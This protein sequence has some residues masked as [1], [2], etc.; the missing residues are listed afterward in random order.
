MIILDDLAKVSVNTVI[1]DG[2]AVS[3]EGKLVTKIDLPI[4]P[5]FAPHGEIEQ[6]SNIERLDYTCKGVRRDCQ[7]T[8]DRSCARKHIHP[9][10]RIGGL[11]EKWFCFSEH[12]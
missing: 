2:R 12:R 6:G 11:R 7:N 5:D 3:K 4:Y 10:F 1:A 8:G 9:S